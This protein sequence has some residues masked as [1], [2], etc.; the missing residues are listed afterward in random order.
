MNRCLI[1]VVSILLAAPQVTW[2]DPSPHGVKHVVVEEN[3]QLEVLDWGGSGPGLVLLAGLG[4][5]AHQFDELA[6][7]LTSRYRVIGVTRRGHPGSSSPATGYGHARLAED[8]LH[9]IDTMGIGKAI[10]VG[11]SFAGEEMHVLGA[12]YSE[13]IRGLVYVDAAFDR[14]DDADNEAYNSVARRC[15]A[16]PAP[17]QKTLPLSRPC[18]L[19]RRELTASP[20]PR[21][22][23]EP[24]SM[25]IRM[26][27]WVASGRR[28]FR[29]GRR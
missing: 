13:K 16:L 21:P 9:V 7:V 27:V 11:H 12:R 29:F 17:N 23:C 15:P 19:F 14:G 10:V 3:V 1:S 2:K 22:S 24:D 18:A 20:K 5:T 25:L 8:V 28:I 26:E 6:P 4:G